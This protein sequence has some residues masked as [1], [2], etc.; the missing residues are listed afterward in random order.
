MAVIRVD[1]AKAL[2][3]TLTLQK[4]C[5]SGFSRDCWVKVQQRVVPPLFNKACAH[6]I[7]DDVESRLTRKHTH[8]LEGRNWP[9]AEPGRI[10]S[11]VYQ[12][13]ATEPRNEN[14][15]MAGIMLI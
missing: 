14:L 11:A 5:G 10:G 4:S 2:S 1:M 15:F 6:S 13:D 9:I 12:I 7:I 8:F 3:F